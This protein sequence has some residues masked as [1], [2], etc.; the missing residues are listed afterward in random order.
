MPQVHQD[1]GRPDRL[2]T[3]VRDTVFF[4]ATMAAMLF[5]LGLSA[6]GLDAILNGHCHD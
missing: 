4:Y 1:L 5:L 3:T 2:E 6:V